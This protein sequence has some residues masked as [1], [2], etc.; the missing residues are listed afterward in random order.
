MK[1]YSIYLVSIYIIL[2][3]VQYADLGTAQKAI[4]KHIG[5]ENIN[6]AKHKPT[7]IKRPQPGEVEINKSI[8]K[9]HDKTQ[10]NQLSVEFTLPWPTNIESDAT[11][12]YVDRKLPA[13]FEND[14]WS[15]RDPVIKIGL[16][17]TDFDP[18]NSF[19]N[20]QGKKIVSAYNTS[21]V[22]TSVPIMYCGSI[23]IPS[24]WE[25]N[26]GN[27]NYNRSDIW[28]RLINSSGLT[29]CPGDACA[30]YL[31]IGFTNRNTAGSVMYFDPT[32][33][34]IVISVGDLMHYDDW[35]QGCGVWS[36]GTLKYFWNG[37]QISEI[38]GISS[39]DQGYIPDTISEYFI[40]ARNT[41]S[42]TTAYWS[43]ASTG[44]AVIANE[45]LSLDWVV[46]DESGSVSYD[47]IT[48]INGTL[49][50]NGIN[51][52]GFLHNWGTVSMSTE[53][54]PFKSLETSNGYRA[55]TNDSN[56]PRLLFNVELGDSS[57]PAD[58]FVISNVIEGGQT[59]ISVNNVGGLGDLTTGLGIL[60]IDASAVSHVITCESFVLDVAS[61]VV[62]DFTYTLVCDTATKSWYLQSETDE[63]PPCIP[64]IPICPT[65]AMNA[66]KHQRRNTNIIAG[67]KN[68]QAKSNMIH[69][70][71]P[72]NR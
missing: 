68:K 37:V 24:E 31:T 72:R 11:L 19:Y 5:N 22:N 21:A 33:G 29:E 45:Y 43:E 34:S 10:T 54:D 18:S 27:T 44:R 48:M 46:N 63:Q 7:D 53:A 69:E 26:A 67:S 32:V 55:F 51:I 47:I 35:N 23:Y 50:S 41:N 9:Y 3:L 16:I 2:L 36:Q 71:K 28:L 12:W 52:N 8:L 56:I 4:F 6:H 17:G 40:Q 64:C 62:S 61:I 30:V 57:S 65:A 60:L 1:H 59:T 20:T 13:I 58:T 14:E 39:G 66:R 25:A 49:I 38:T 70:F 15:G 42:T